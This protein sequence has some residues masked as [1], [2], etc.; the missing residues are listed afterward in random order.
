MSTKRPLTDKEIR[1]LVNDAVDLTLPQARNLFAQYQ[2]VESDMPT[3]N[4]AA[5]LTNLLD[6][7]FYMRFGGQW[8]ATAAPHVFQPIPY[9]RRLAA[10]STATTTPPEPTVSERIVRNIT[11]ALFAE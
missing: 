3:D 2:Q 6:A 11:R 4:Y 5:T 7:I 1:A 8:R 9:T 10:P